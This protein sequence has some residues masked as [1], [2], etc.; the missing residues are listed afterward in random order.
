MS[1][2]MCYLMLPGVSLDEY[3]PSCKR[4]VSLSYSEAEIY[5]LKKVSLFA[6]QNG[7]GDANRDKQLNSFIC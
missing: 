7:Q 1:A 2:S 4:T 3:L 5:Q 6:S